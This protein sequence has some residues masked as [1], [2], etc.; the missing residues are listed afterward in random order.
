MLDLKYPS[1][2]K[3]LFILVSSL[4]PRRHTQLLILLALMLVA[5]I[6]EM[7]SLGA[8]VPFLAILSDPE[9]AIKTPLVA[10]VV[11]AM[12]LGAD[13]DIRWELTV[14]FAGAALA[15]GILRFMLIYAA[16]KINFGIGH[17]LGAEVYRR[18]LYQQ[19]EVH[20][21]RN[22][23]EIMGGVSKVD[24]VVFVI[25]SM[26][27]TVSVIIMAIAIIVTLL[28]I[29]SFVSCIALCSFGSI[30]IGISFLTRKRL[31]ESSDIVNIAYNARI[32]CMQEGLGGI[33][34]I[35]LDH[36]QP[37]FSKRFNEIDWPMR[38]AQ[39][40]VSIIGP[41][42]RFAVEALGT[43]LIA[44]LGYYMMTSGGGVVAALPTLGAL[45]LGAQRLMP[46]LQQ[47]Y[48][49]WVYVKS[50]RQ[51]LIDVA[52]LLQQT[53]ESKKNEKFTA[54]PFN[55]EIRI[56][57]VS[58]KY[59]SHLPFI[60][61]KLNLRISKGARIGVIGATGSGKST[62]IDLL[63]GL[64]QPISGQISVDDT[65]ITGGARMDWQRNVA[66]VPQSIF[67]ADASFAENIA[68]AVQTDL[69]DIDRVKRAAQQAQIAEFIESSPSGYA[70]KVGERGVRLSGGQRQR[71][72]IARALYR[73]AK[74]L[75]LDEATSALDNE[76]E[77]S[78]MQA[79]ESL[80][81]EYTTLIIAHRLTTLKN[82]T[83]IVELSDGSIKNIGTFKDFFPKVLDL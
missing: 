40:S 7:I 75:V 50:S 59:Q 62:L 67:L 31:V 61:R 69:I 11:A 71:I 37:L 34:D 65:P 9:Q 43:I 4:P 29:D 73:E 22:S 74:I 33:R 26:I 13:K 78:V 27:N 68:F 45:A 63:M 51:I 70:A 35:L 42:P 2:I 47:S 38:Q 64:L 14:M 1:F 41:S 8:I 66:H 80:S 12:G 60:L 81:D 55:Y 28:L 17:E 24:N 72:G 18:T 20:I 44:L 36:A 54:L 19:Y 77:S 46:L 25:Y 10:Q 5:A 3:S 21:A 56:E 15:A 32:Q 52:S 83:Q 16:A 39:A 30:Y 6:V 57:N 76:T 49:G 79:I 23:S 48:Q 53:I 82:C 58:F